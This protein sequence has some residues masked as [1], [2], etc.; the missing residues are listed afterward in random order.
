MTANQNRQRSKS[1][2]KALCV[3]VFVLVAL[4]GDNAHAGAETGGH[5]TSEAEHTIIRG[6]ESGPHYIEA[7]FA[8]LEGGI[9]CD[10]TSYEGTST[11][12]TATELIIVPRYGK[13]HTTGEGTTWEIP[14][15]GCVYNFTI[16]KEALGSNTADIECPKGASIE[17]PDGPS[18]CRGSVPS[19][20]VSGVDYRTIVENNTHLITL[21]VLAGVMWNFESKFCAGFF[22]T[23][24]FALIGGSVTV[25]GFDTEG[26]PVGITATGWAD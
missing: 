11:S 20:T 13:C 5:F 22:G 7:G 10:E 1:R 9:V 18:G 24:H 15:N 6:V 25:G 4:G 21:D 17:I 3:G 12:A 26:N 16:G 23:E 14:T 19:Q 8:G 2:L